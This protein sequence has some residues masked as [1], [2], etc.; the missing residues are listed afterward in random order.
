MNEPE[1][2]TED[3]LLTMNSSLQETPSETS[4]LLKKAK[5]TVS[6][7]F[8]TSI[9]DDEVLKLNP[10]E[11]FTKYKTLPCLQIL[12]ILLILSVI[13]LVIFYTVPRNS[14]YRHVGTAISENFLPEDFQHS[15]DSFKQHMHV[16]FF[17]T[18][19]IFEDIKHTVDHYYDFV[20]ASTGGFRYIKKKN[21]DIRPVKLTV[22]LYSNS[23]RDFISNKTNPHH[24]KDSVE[25]FFFY[26]PE[27]PTV[28][29]VTTENPFGSILNV[30]EE[31]QRVL[32]DR[33]K[34]VT[35]EFSFESIYIHAITYE[36]GCVRW[37]VKKDYDFSIRH[38]SIPLKFTYTYSYCNHMVDSAFKKITTYLQAFVIIISV[39]SLFFNFTQFGY[40]IFIFSKKF[41][42]GTEKLKRIWKY[43]QWWNVVSAFANILNILGSSILIV[44]IETETI[45][46][47]G[48][49]FAG[50]GAYFTMVSSLRN[51][52]HFPRLY[53]LVQALQTGLPGIM[54]IGIGTFPFFFA[55]ALGGT[56]WFGHFSRVFETVLTSCVTLFC[57]MHGDVI[58]DVFNEAFGLNFF[59]RLLSRVYMFSFVVMIICVILNQFLVTLEESYLG[60]GFNI[61]ET[62]NAFAAFRSNL[63]EDEE[64]EDSSENSAGNEEITLDGSNDKNIQEVNTILQEMIDKI[65]NV[66]ND[67][68]TRDQEKSI[69]L[70]GFYASQFLRK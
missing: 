10:F 66:Q 3:E 22:Q 61:S 16:N 59:I 5:G 28:E 6:G 12:D 65:K 67:E 69:S 19:E 37:H 33:I 60:L 55:Y 23:I 26:N 42:N 21:G 35:Q 20:D 14:Y 56:I 18:H 58:R 52:F 15:E 1:H 41:K 13:V 70:I 44:N 43:I 34:S 38:G 7:I 54:R 31:E 27:K 63:N 2:E 68:L 30:T 46:L 8:G 48:L 17:E 64:G 45:V 50:S 24:S 4:T 9:P 57:I 29:F 36:L 47:A 51:Y 11:K 53:F 39:L 25:P 62:Q 32:S 40:Y 49:F